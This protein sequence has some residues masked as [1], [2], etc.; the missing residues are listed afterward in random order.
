[1]NTR[2]LLGKLG[3]M[4][5]TLAFVIVFNFFLFRVM[6]DPTSQLA[7]LPQASPQ[8]IEQ[9]KHDYGLDK[10]LGGQFTA[11]VGDTL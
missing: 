10:S 6:G 5:A 1:M 11:Y 2:W 4:A 9:L 7:R 3:A 8:E